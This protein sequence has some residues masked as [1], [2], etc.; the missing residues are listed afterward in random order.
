MERKLA[1]LNTLFAQLDL[2]RKTHV[3]KRHCFG[4]EVIYVKMAVG[5]G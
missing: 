4:K 1:L 5:K 2:N 3:T